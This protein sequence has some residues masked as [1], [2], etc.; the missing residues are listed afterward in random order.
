MTSF[1]SLSMYCR[2]NAG[3]FLDEIPNFLR[4]YN[5]SIRLTS[6]VWDHVCTP[7]FTAGLRRAKPIILSPAICILADFPRAYKAG[8]RRRGDFCTCFI[9]TGC[10]CVFFYVSTRQHS[11]NMLTR[12][13]LNITDCDLD[14][15]AV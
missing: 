10:S 11:V 4:K 6:K 8:S 3:W 9:P 12:V 1:A 15:N 2:V 5:S 13:A 14:H 7:E